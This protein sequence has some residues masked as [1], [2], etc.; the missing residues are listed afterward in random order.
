MTFSSWSRSQAGLD[1]V[2]GME[3]AAERDEIVLVLC[4]TPSPHKGSECSGPAGQE[5]TAVSAHSVSGG[6]VSRAPLGWSWT[7][8]RIVMISWL[9]TPVEETLS[10]PGAD[11]PST[12][13]VYSYSASNGGVWHSPGSSPVSVHMWGDTA[14]PPLSC[15]SLTEGNIQ[16]RA[17]HNS[18]SRDLSFSG[19]EFVLHINSW[20][21]TF[22]ISFI[23]LL[24][25][26][27][28]FQ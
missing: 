1:C 27:F 7:E 12:L 23:Y 17:V 24:H 18:E 9:E 26:H 4:N 2:S 8:L 14:T 3:T 6:T 21:F 10:C 25:E 28:K 15:L 22:H 20:L 16:C 13:R 11:A 19:F 5:R